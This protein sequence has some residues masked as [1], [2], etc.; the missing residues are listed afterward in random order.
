M[1]KSK[2]QKRIAPFSLSYLIRVAVQDLKMPITAVVGYSE[3]LNSA[4]RPS[5]KQMTKYFLKLKKNS[6]WAS[7]AIMGFNQMVQVIE[8]DSPL[9]EIDEVD[10]IATVKK[11][12]RRFNGN[13][14]PNQIRLKIASRKYKCKTDPNHLL[15]ILT[16]LIDAHV[17]SHCEALPM[18]IEVS[19]KAGNVNI[20]LHT[21]PPLF[22]TYNTSLLN[23]FFKAKNSVMLSTCSLGINLT[24][25][26]YLADQ[27][28]ISISAETT[29][30]Q[31]T[32]LIISLK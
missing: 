3:L 21:E 24:L 2:S 29:I 6:T 15:T 1:N 7:N 19:K 32:N 31:N 8:G 28:E 14:N 13:Y 9:I 26:K 10:I 12:I 30:F 27:L 4:E 17:H 16:Q 23:S 5:S 20:V 22:A 18:E 25:A 11:V